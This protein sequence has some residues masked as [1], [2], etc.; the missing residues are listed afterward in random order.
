MKKIL[1]AALLVVA[2]GSAAL[3]DGKTKMLDDL[4]AALRSS[5]AAFQSTESYKKASF[6]F[7]GKSVSA[8][9]DPQNEDLIGFSIT[10]DVNDLPQGAM[11]NISKKYQG[12]TVSEAILF[13]DDQGATSHYAKVDK[14]GRSIALQVSPKGKVNI[15]AQMPH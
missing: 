14:N 9:F 15:Y 11:E 10:I 13:I 1:L 3:A 7:N 5:H 2:F 12:W 8:Y 6:V 4:K